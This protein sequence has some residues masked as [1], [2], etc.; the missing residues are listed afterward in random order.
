[1]AEV[2]P[3]GQANAASL[4]DQAAEGERAGDEEP[5]ERGVEDGVD[6]EAGPDGEVREKPIVLDYPAIPRIGHR[7]N[8][9][10]ESGLISRVLDVFL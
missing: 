7:H 10:R 8:R 3:A 6:G 1:M 4:A 9:D 5:E 2:I